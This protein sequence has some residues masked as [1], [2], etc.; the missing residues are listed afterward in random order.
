MLCHAPDDPRVVYLYELYDDERPFQ[1]HSAS[2][3][4]RT[5]AARTTSWVKR[6]TVHIYHRL[7]PR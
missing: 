2:E 7:D 1:P 3:H 6:K 5:F 4:Y